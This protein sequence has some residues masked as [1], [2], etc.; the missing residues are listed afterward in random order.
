M[1]DY[2]RIWEAW[3][4]C[5]LALHLRYENLLTDYE[6]EVA[7]LTGFLDIERGTPEV[8]EVIEKYRPRGAQPNQ[9]GLHFSQGKIGRFRQR[10]TVEQQ[11]I[12]A[13]KFGPYLE[14]MGYPID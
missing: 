5:D 7:R 1:L 8:G 9:K 12:L 13:G 2:L 4:E 14:R 11:D 6:L 3:M 10:M